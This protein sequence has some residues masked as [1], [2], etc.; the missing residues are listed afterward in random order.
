MKNKFI[1]IGIFILLI[2]IIISVIYYCNVYDKKLVD[3]EDILTDSKFQ[4]I[5]YNETSNSDDLK[6]GVLGIIKI[7][8]IRFK[9]RDKRR[10]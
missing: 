10:L 5:T 2:I 3:P 8:K 7:E 9:S 4:N 1:I 6:N